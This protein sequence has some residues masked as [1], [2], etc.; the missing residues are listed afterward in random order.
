[1]SVFDRERSAQQTRREVLAAREKETKANENMVMAASSAGHDEDVGTSALLIDSLAAPPVVVLSKRSRGIATPSAEP[2]AESVTVGRSEPVRAQPLSER[3]VAGRSN[4]PPATPLERV[5]AGHV[6]P[7]LAPLPLIPPV[8]HA[9]PDKLEDFDD[10]ERDDQ[11]G[12]ARGDPESDERE[13]SDDDVQDEHLEPAHTPP[14]VEPAAA[15]PS[16]H[17]AHSESADQTI[18]SRDIRTA[19]VA[20]LKAP[21]TS[22]ARPSALLSN[23]AGKSEKAAIA[24]AGRLRRARRLSGARTARIRRRKEEK[25]GEGGRN[26]KNA[27]KQPL[28]RSIRSKCIGGVANCW[29]YCKR[30]RRTGH[31]P[32]P[33][34]Q[35]VPPIQAVSASPHPPQPPQPRA[36]AESARGWDSSAGWSADLARVHAS[37]LRLSVLAA[38][39]VVAGIV[40]AGIARGEIDLTKLVPGFTASDGIPR[41]I[42]RDRSLTNIGTGP[43][44]NVEILKPT[45]R[46][47]G[48]IAAGS[49]VPVPGDDFA[50][51]W[52]WTANNK[53]EDDNRLFHLADPVTTTPGSRS[54]TEV[55]LESR[56]DP[57]LGDVPSGMKAT[58]DPVSHILEITAD[59]CIEVKADGYLLRP[60][61]RSTQ[62]G[63]EYRFS[64][65]NILVIGQDV[66][67]GQ[68]VRFEVV[69]VKP[70][71]FYSLPLYVRTEGSAWTYFTVSVSSKSNV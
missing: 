19:A 15:T 58:Y 2:V 12:A 6:K 69:F 18:P 66:D 39:I 70:Q 7:A 50:V 42:V 33:V 54:K 65:T 23:R 62:L 32:M 3:V 49:S 26:N 63:S 36:A 46:L 14:L 56:G 67:R 34:S 57:Y 60:T 9:E 45:Y 64:Q 28:W 68:S 55:M 25:R 30:G 11:D 21:P 5:A 13:D 44:Q 20:A 4:L 61:G 31:V 1:M 10:G 38:A 48:T 53:T 47:I 41:L 22:P 24:T 29:S 35:P 43:A 8:A 51:R 71:E 40:A 52:E 17:S 59:T 37:K 27:G 16:G